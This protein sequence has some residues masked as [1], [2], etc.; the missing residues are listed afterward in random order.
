MHSRS[1]SSLSLVASLGTSN[2]YY[3]DI[4]TQCKESHEKWCALETDGLPCHPHCRPPGQCSGPSDS[5]TYTEDENWVCTIDWMKEGEHIWGPDM[6]GHGKTD[7]DC[8]VEMQDCPLNAWNDPTS[9]RLYCPMQFKKWCEQNDAS[10]L[11]N[12]P[13]Q[14]ARCEHLVWRLQDTEKSTRWVCSR[15]WEFTTKYDMNIIWAHGKPGFDSTQGPNSI[16]N[17]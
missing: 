8:D 5:D 7:L 10:S 2:G 9:I 17:I 13:E 11:A 16:E 14:S 4:I 15:D 6:L 12:V 1:C 3:D